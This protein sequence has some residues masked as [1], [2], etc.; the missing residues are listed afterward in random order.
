MSPDRAI[1]IAE[2]K[3]HMVCTGF[4]YEYEGDYYLEMAPQDYNP[5][6]D[7]AIS[8]SC[9]KVDSITAKVT[10]YSPAVNGIQ[11]IRKMH[12]FN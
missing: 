9:Y 3:L 6:K 4:G 2:N 7:G 12:F 10:P 11:D 1:K 5:N 8:D